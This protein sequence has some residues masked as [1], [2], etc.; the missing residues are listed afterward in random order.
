MLSRIVPHQKSTRLVGMAQ[1][2]LEQ[3]WAELPEPVGTR[4]VLL[5]SR[6][7]SYQYLSRVLAVE[8]TRRV[9]GIVQE[10]ALGVRERLAPS[11]AAR[12]AGGFPMD[13][14]WLSGSLRARNEPMDVHSGMR[15][16]H[17]IK[18]ATS[19]L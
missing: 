1:G 14:G 16:R 4:P 8:V 2:P 19:R 7:G 12:P 9:R 17:P 15:Q 10:I 11:V 3:W 5:L 6:A 18:P 13:A